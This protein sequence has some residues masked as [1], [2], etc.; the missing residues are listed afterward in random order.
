LLLFIMLSLKGS[1]ILSNITGICML[2]SLAAGFYLMFKNYIKAWKVNINTYI[3]NKDL[4]LA[5]ICFVVSSFILV[6]IFTSASNFTGVYSQP[7]SFITIKESAVASLWPNVY[8]TV[9][10]LNDASLMQ[11]IGTLGGKL[12][13]AISLLGVLL[14]LTL[15]KDGK[16]DVRYAIL[17]SIWFAGTMYA[18]TK[19]IR[20]TLLLAPA[21]AIAIGA[22][23]GISFKY[24]SKW[25]VKELNIHKI[26]ANTV[27]VILMVMILI[28]PIKAANA[29]VRSEVPSMNDA[30][31]TALTNIKTNSTEDA[32]IN[33]WWDFGHWFKAVADRAVTFDGASQN[34]PQAHWIGHVLLTSDEDEA[35]GILR[36]L[37]C[38][39]NT[40]FDIL[41]NDTESTIKSVEFLYK[42]IPVDKEQAREILEKSSLNLHD[43]DI[44]RVLQNTH[45]APPENYFITSEDMVGKAGVW[46]H[47][48][49]WDFE[50]AFVWRDLRKEEVDKA[51]DLMVKGFGYSE[52]TAQKL[53]YETQSITNEKD[54]NNWI[55]PWPGYAATVSCP[56][57]DN[58]TIQCVFRI[59]QRPNEQVI[60]FIVDIAEMEAMIETNQGKVYPSSISY[61]QDDKFIERVYENSTIPYSITL[62][63]K[64]INYK[65]VLMSPQL[66]GSMFTRLFYHNG[67]GLKHFD[68]FDHQVDVTGQNIITWKVDWQG[69][70]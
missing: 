53:Y 29:T 14:T 2:I 55:S 66:A 57:V 25:A 59:G 67:V 44:E 32:I 8:T 22:A 7:V 26:I 27:L 31:Y 28:V 61:V 70:E 68:K 42:I 58:K 56:P 47:F 10:E 5:L 54:A 30:W 4:L 43:E 38:G 37:D 9:A 40:A 1:N 23:V 19:G 20:F 46:A 17:L 65:A 64:D 63:K 60:P 21:F 24:I 13:F 18:S 36:M 41:K 12:M 50:K 11:I 51:V 35:I 52:E 6:S 48:G 15:K 16:T 49:S 3:E 45:C 33:S 39:A 69:K 62:I 34:R